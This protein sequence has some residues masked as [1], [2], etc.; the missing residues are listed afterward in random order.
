MT[1]SAGTKLGS[2]EILAAL[3][4]GGMGEVYRARDSKL[5][6][7]VAVKVLPDSVAGDPAA[8]ARFEREAKA[9]AALSHPNILAI[10]DFG[11]QGGVSYA[12]MEL[13]EGETLRG[14][15]E[16]GPVSPNRSVDYALQVARG[17]AAAHEK[18]VVHRD[19]KPEN[20]FVTRDG[21]VKILDFGLA[22]RFETAAPE[23]ETGAPTV[24]S[25]TEPGT[26]MGTLGYMSPEQVR[27]L[28]IDH[29]SD[30]FS[31]GAVLYELLYGKRAFAR[32]TAADTMSAILKED[33]P[34]PAD[35]ERRTSPALDRIVRH[36][37]EKD[38][39]N[40]FQSARDVA[41]NLSEESSRAAVS[42]APPP[43]A[44]RRGARI[45][46]AVLAVVAVLGVAGVVLLRR[47]RGV[48]AG[49]G[50]VKR[51]AVLPFENLGSP[52][53]D[54]FTDGIADEV[55]AKLTALPSLQV[56]ARASSTPYKKTSKA[57]REIAGELNA[58][59]LLTA[60]VRWEKAG[61]GSRV[62][63]T[64]ELVDV[65]RPDAPTSKW[66]QP[67]D[68]SLTD[69]FQVQSEIASRVAQALGVALGAGEEKRL[70]EKPTANVAAYEA[71]L[72]GEEI[73]RRMAVGDPA[74][75]RQAIGFYDQAVAL[76]PDFAQAWSRISWGSATL[77][78]I[79]TPTP[80]LAQRARET[81][82]KA[83]A[84][85][86]TLA[87]AYLALGNYQRLVLK[88]FDRATEQYNR[89]HRAAAA[90]ADLLTATGLAEMSLGHWE[91]ALER[92]RQVNRLDPRS[93]RNHTR[94]SQTL[95]YLHRYPEAREAADKGL[96]VVSDNLPLI[97]HKA[98]TFLGEGDLEAAR[99]VILSAAGKV[100]PTRLAAFLANAYDLVWV[101]DKEQLA[102]LLRLT[103]SAFDGD[104]SAWGACLLQAAA[105]EAD[106][107]GVRKYAE[108]AAKNLEEQLRSVP[109]DA[110]RRVVRGL[111][112]A[113][114]GRKEEAIREGERAA[115][116]LPVSRD[117]VDGPYIQHLLARI[118][119]VAG[120]PEKALDRLES[121]L[122]T[123]YILSPGWLKI[124]PNFD[125]LRG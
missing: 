59:Y 66:Q 53:D 56:I 51:V 28:S 119:I 36:C 11:R 3:G 100:E 105:L 5:D 52:E 54:Y 73:W 32:P 49:A 77:Y 21:H 70:S 99:R 80:E 39:E 37:L 106:A 17:L 9:V 112:L 18:G 85:A 44:S 47:P 43:R 64:P 29:R 74:G 16:A 88:D 93:I 15:L 97:E 113:Y 45:V 61:G 58:P 6:R 13:L 65:T 79:S 12:V 8:L 76:D 108:V 14:K 10:H 114:L 7:D 82:E 1:L 78:A 87:E 25:H 107:E 117:A 91:S 94:M 60:T 41:F 103:P 115:V 68:A 89:G 101:L 123:P 95:T 24:T 111:A 110:P 96:A 90:N 72:K 109:D 46:A 124:D 34:E 35:P 50:G 98:M 2:Y 40:R 121:L 84:L 81:A 63:V 104:R 75:L 23:G 122:K 26:V 55:R 42:A 86:P 125:A 69:V 83:V 102:L 20:L 92:F 67:F 30:I 57:P 31:F 22:K 62:H 48:P 120:E 118:Y 71:F 38:R 33:P 116:L 19:L 27:G 4:A